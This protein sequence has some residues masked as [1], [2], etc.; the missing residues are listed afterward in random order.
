MLHLKIAIHSVQVKI[1]K[2]FSKRPI[3]AVP[4]LIGTREMQTR[5]SNIPMQG[6]S[7]QRSSAGSEAVQRR[8]SPAAC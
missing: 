4:A 8:T 6:P 5:V 3:G 7:Q 2:Y 1:L